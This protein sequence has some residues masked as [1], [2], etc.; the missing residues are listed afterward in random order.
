[1]SSWRQIWYSIWI[2]Q[3]FIID[4]PI[5][6]FDWSYF[7]QYSAEGCDAYSYWSLTRISDGAVLKGGNLT[8]GE[9]GGASGI[10]TEDVSAYI[11]T[12]ARI[13]FTLRPSGQRFQFESR[14]RI[15]NVKVYSPTCPSTP[16]FSGDTVTLKATPIQG[17]APYTVE[18]RMSPPQSMINDETGVT[19][20]IPPSRLGGPN[21]T[22][23]V[24]EG[25]AITRAYILDGVD[26]EGATTKTP[27]EGPSIIFAAEMI[28]SCAPSQ[29]CI[30]YCKVFVGC[31]SPVCDFTVT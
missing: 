10:I 11:G 17:V 1:M 4:N 15:G 30:K 7:E 28:D 19:E 21:P 13:R 26:L 24:T 2:L 25:T 12:N 9:C 14:L 20:V 31:T 8:G 6:K 22:N 18:F 29:S 5:L 3:D 23:N 27:G 16:K